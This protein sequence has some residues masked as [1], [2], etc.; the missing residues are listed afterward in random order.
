LVEL[1]SEYVVIHKTVKRLFHSM[2]VLGKKE[3]SYNTH[4]H[5]IESTLSLQIWSQCC[6]IRGWKSL[7]FEEWAFLTCAN[8]TY[9]I[10]LYLYYILTV[11]VA[12]SEIEEVIL[13]NKVKT[14]GM[15]YACTRI[16]CNRVVD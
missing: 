7:I 11:V 8:F 2:I 3:F 15:F 13:N 10:T 14:H 1:K 9:F 5:L 6:S 12:I 16:S 4:L